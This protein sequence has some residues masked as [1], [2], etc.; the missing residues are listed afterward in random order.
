LAGDLGGIKRVATKHGID[1]STANK[2]IAVYRVHG[3]SG[4][5]K[6][7]T[8]Y[9]AE[10]K[11]KVLTCMRDRSLSH[12]E[13]AA[14]FDIRNRSIIGVWERAYD[15]AGVKALYPRPRG[16]P[17]KMPKK[18][19]PPPALPVTDESRS[20][21]ELLDELNY[22]RM[23]NAYL[24]KLDALIHTNKLSAPNKKRK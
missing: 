2:W 10:F 11:L 6:K 5:V 19:P 4:L 22:L 13:T 3:E 14:I 9:S 7:F 16:Q 21:Q 20:R 24:K 1:G 15:L 18:N 23:E 17:P 12:R 8:H